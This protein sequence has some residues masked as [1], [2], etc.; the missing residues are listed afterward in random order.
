MEFLT[1]LWKDP[2]WSKVI[3]TGIIALIAVIAT[4]I[5][6]LWPDIQSIIKILWDLITSSTKTPNWL[7]ALM[8]APCIL[9]AS[10]LISKFKYK[11]SESLSFTDY[12]EDEFDGLLWL[13]NYND[14]KIV[15]LHSICPKCSYQ[16]I[17]KSKPN[18][19][20]GGSIYRY[21]CDDCG[22]ASNSLSIEPHELEHNIR[23]KIQKNL[24]T[25]EW[26]E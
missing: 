25:G 20:R 7:L 8:A 10:D 15:H 23:L 16:I 11:E 17:P 19:Q 1:K 2:V 13:W 22:Y 12:T 24:R 4:Y 5:L 18:Y 14:E 21:S 3:A 6:D 9:F 26:I